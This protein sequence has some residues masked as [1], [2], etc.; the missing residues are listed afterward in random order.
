[1][2]GGVSHGI[3][4]SGAL[5]LNVATWSQDNQLGRV[6]VCQ[7]RCP[8]SIADNHQVLWNFQ[9]RLHYSWDT[10]DLTSGKVSQIRKIK[11]SYPFLAQQ[12]IFQAI[13]ILE[14]VRAMH[15]ELDAYCRA[16]EQCSTPRTASAKSK[17]YSMIGSMASVISADISPHTLFQGRSTFA[18]SNEVRGF[19]ISEHAYSRWYLEYKELYMEKW[20]E[21][22]S[23][24]D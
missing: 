5:V 9:R 21:T 1:M 3:C 18:R 2:Q 11:G 14:R 13:H 23:Y 10:L 20:D 24:R 22:L 16:Q 17:L 15:W 8:Q 19:S 6:S 4:S 12:Y 7:H